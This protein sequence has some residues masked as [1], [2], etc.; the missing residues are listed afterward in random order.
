MEY[1]GSMAYD[2]DAFF[3]NYLTRRNRETSPNNSIEKPALLELIGD[4]TDKRVLDLGCGD[5]KFG[6]ELIDQ[7][8]SVYDGVEGSTN[9]VGKARE[10]L[11]GTC[12]NVYHSTMEKW[13]YPTER[14][15][16]VISRLALHYIEELL[17]IFKKVYDSLQCDG[18]FV[19]SVQHPVLT[20]S[21]KSAVNS[22]KKTDWIVDD[23]FATGKRVEPWID[24]QVVKYHRTIEEYFRLLVQ[25]GF[26]IEY[27][28]E[29]TPRSE[30]FDSKEEYQRRKRIP[31]FLVFSCNL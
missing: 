7:G 31:L 28:S 14:Y 15:D 8:C 19:F 22:G 6:Y 27:I 16:L 13:D 17:P 3:E 18:S 5:G 10:T 25:A 1:K 2:N 24:Q 29:C 4:V 12:G 26:T 20:S 30:L 21:I 23:Y 11:A 9:M